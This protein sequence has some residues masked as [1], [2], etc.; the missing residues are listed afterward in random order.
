M[1]WGNLIAFYL[2][3]AGASAGAFLTSAFVEKRYP[4][5]KKIRIAGRVI[6]PIFI[7]IGMVLLILDAEAGLYNPL[8]FV[9]LVMNPTSVMTI[10]VYALCVYMPIIFLSL[11][12]EILKKKI[13]FAMTI[14]GCVGAVAVACYTGFL[15]GVVSPV[16]LWNNAMLP[17]LFP[18]SG[19]SAGLS[20]TCFVGLIL[21]R[22]SVSNMRQIKIIHLIA[23]GVEILALFVM[24]VIVSSSDPAGLASVTSIISGEYALMFWGLVIGTGIVIPT[25]VETRHLMSKGHHE[26]SSADYMT[27]LCVEAFVVA[28]GLALRF[29]VVGAAVPIAFL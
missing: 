8:R 26:I 19:I 24:M 4:D 5:A 22:V 10:G 17:I 21:D 12:L 29:I 20:M 15:L 7:A 9:Y 6:A 3:L 11:L 25:I 14:V 13:P 27:S 23:F 16:P 18:V 2:F 1:V 28:G